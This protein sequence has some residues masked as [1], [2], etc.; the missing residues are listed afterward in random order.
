MGGR[1]NAASSKE[2]ARS[3]SK[4]GGFAV[5]H[6]ADTATVRRCPTAWDTPVGNPSQRLTVQHFILNKTD[7]GCQAA[8]FGVVDFITLSE[9]EF[10]YLLENI[11]ASPDYYNESNTCCSLPPCTFQS[12]Q[13][14]ESVFL[15]I[16]YSLLF[17]LGLCGNCMVLLVMLQCKQ[18]LAGTDMFILHLAIADTLLVVTLPFWAVQAVHGWVFSTSTCKLIGSIFKI[19]FYSSIFFLVCISF[20][21][22]LSIVHA[23]HM[24]KRKKSQLMVASCLVVWGVCIL[25]TIPDFLY[26]AVKLD[27]RLNTTSCSLEFT[28]G[29]SLSWKVALRLCYHLLGFFL[30]LAAMLYCYICIIH[31]LLRSQGFHKHKA[32]RVIF[33]VVAVFFLCWT[34][35]HLALL[36]T[37][38]IDLGLVARD[39]TWEARL[40]IALS[41]TASLG[42][43]H[44]GLNPLLYAFIGIKFR[45]KVLEQLGRL[46]CVSRDFLRRHLPRLSQLRDSTWSETTE[47]SYSGL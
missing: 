16:F 27:R 30:P 32:M 18:S 10:S 35:Y 29:T 6:P 24:Y 41:V 9:D 20:D 39:C 28:S 19:N 21:R 26:L 47:A 36:V 17:P 2:G 38:L 1:H 11:S 13:A 7:G 43:F 3:C 37:T 25:L 5:F 34:P 23:V 22:Y 45:S 8:P 46:G 12:L 33:A 40:D 42:Y 4:G 15:P 31:T 44:C 14:F